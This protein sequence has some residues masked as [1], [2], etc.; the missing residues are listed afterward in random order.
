[1]ETRLYKVRIREPRGCVQAVFVRAVDAN[2]AVALARPASARAT[3]A[4]VSV[5]AE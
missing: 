4:S 1:M 5:V 2:E 3:I